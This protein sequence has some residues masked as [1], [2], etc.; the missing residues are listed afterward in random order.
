MIA[1]KIR[2]FGHPVH[3]TLV[4][5]PLGLF[6]TAV[7]FDI[8]R[9]LGQSSDLTVASFWDICAGVVSGAIAGL[10]G[11]LDFRSIPRATRAKRI[12]V[13][14]GVLNVLLTIL[15]AVAAALRSGLPARGL[16]TPALVLELV[17]LGMALVTGWLG[18]EL[19]ERL[20]VGVDAAAHLDAPSSLSK[21]GR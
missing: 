5:L 2:L 16:T 10:F 20:G 11:A 6:V 12:G 13:A 14:H 21:Q 17:A 9:V 4:H 18:G 8:I 7:L 15:F 1:K 19:V 3:P